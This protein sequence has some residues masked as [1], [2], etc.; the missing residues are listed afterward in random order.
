MIAIDSVESKPIAE[1][2]SLKIK[3]AR[4]KNGMTIEQLAEKSSLAV[5]TIKQVESGKKDCYASTIFCIAKAL[6]ISLDY[7]FGR[8]VLFGSKNMEVLYESLTDSQKNAVEGFS[9]WLKLTGDRYIP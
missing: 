2:I 7:L 9:H 1:I 6:N 3:E 8:E 5:Q 4:H